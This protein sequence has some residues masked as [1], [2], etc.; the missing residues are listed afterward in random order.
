MSGLRYYLSVGNTVRQK[1]IQNNFR[2]V[3][4]VM[5][6]IQKA[7]DT[8]IQNNFKEAFCSWVRLPHYKNLDNSGSAVAIFQVDMENYFS[9]EDAVAN[10]LTVK[11]QVEDEISDVCKRIA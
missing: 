11:R 6:I 3:M 4:D 9:G 2:D 8:R 7:I 5:G 1:S 10:G